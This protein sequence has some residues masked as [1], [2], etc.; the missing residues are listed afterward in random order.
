MISKEVFEMQA[1]L[2]QAMGNPARLEIVH[3]LRDGPRHVSEL[4]KIM[5]I[6]QSTLSRHLAILK[7]NG[8]VNSDRQGQE[9]IYQ[10]SNP[11]IVAVCDLMRQVLADQLT[12]QSE[13]VNYPPK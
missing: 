3:L 6:S 11:K 13:I 12:H 4:S 8:V 10:L 5:D 1:R 2:C 7:R 9:V